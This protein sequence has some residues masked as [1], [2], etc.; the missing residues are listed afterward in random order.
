MQLIDKID[1]LIQSRR[2]SAEVQRWLFS[3]V[4]LGVAFVFFF[5]LILPM[6]ITHKDMVVVT[7]LAAGFAGLQ[8]YWMFRGWQRNE[9]LTVLLGFLGIVLA[10]LFVWAYGAV[11]GDVLPQVFRGWVR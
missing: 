2:D 5:L 8:G 11:L 7:G 6:E 9:G 1:H 3:L 10:A 4:P